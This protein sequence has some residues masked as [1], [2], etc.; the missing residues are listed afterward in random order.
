MFIRNLK[1]F[2][3]TANQAGYATDNPSHEIKEKN[4]TTTITYSQS[5]WQMIDSYVGGEPFAGYT[6]ILYQKRVIFAMA[7]YGKIISAKEKP[8]NVYT[9][10]KKALLKMPP[11]HPYRGPKNFREGEWRY[12]NEWRGEIAEFSGQE[13]IFHRQKEVFWTKYIGGLVNQ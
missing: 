10:L 7:Y 11:E 13:K 12:N 1:N 2:L 5:D 6:K 3:F 4:G 9:F 8:A